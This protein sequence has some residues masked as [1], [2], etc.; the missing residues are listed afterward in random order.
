MASRSRSS[1]I[2]AFAAT[3]EAKKPANLYEVLHLKETA[4]P[5]EIKTA[6]RTLAKRLHPDA[7]SHG[8]DARDFIEIHQAYTKLSDPTARQQ[9][10]LS[11]G[12]RF[13]FSTENRSAYTYRPRRWETDQ[14]W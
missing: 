4:S 1:T 5:L 8:S 6:Y 7:I 2:L 11:I 14:C 12:S 9:Y 10:D 3:V 13:R